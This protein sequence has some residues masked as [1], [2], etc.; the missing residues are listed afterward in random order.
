MSDNF[1]DHF[2]ET[3]LGA[4]Q[5]PSYHPNVQQALQL[6][7]QWDANRYSQ[8]NFNSS[9]ARAAQQALINSTVEHSKWVFN[10]QPMTVSDFAT[11][12]YGEDTPERTMFLLQYAEIS[13]GETK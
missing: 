11:R 12:V 8:N 6:S 10:G 2:F 9:L 3:T 4:I 13:Q 5:Q 7:H 1:L